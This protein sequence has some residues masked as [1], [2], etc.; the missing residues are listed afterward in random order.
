MENMV[1][2]RLTAYIESISFIKP[3]QSGFKKLHS[4]MDPLVRFTNAIQETFKEGDYLVAIF[5]D[6]EKAYDM[7]WRRLVLKILNDIGLTGH[8]PRFIENFLT[9]RKIKVKIGDFL[10]AAFILENGLPQGSVL[11]CILFSLIINSILEEADLV[12]KSLF[13]DDGLFWAR[14]PTLEIAVARI[15]NALSCIEEWC[16]YHGPKISITKT[17][18]NVFK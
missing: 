7:V 2:V 6:L 3:Y 15:R 8:L 5:I 16:E 13:C 18:Y 9:N 17:H 1:L 14:G 4:T 11:S 10:S 12:S